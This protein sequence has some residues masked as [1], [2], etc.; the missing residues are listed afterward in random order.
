M[1]F[2]G[3]LNTFHS[4]LLKN[5]RIDY[6]QNMVLEVPESIRQIGEVCNFGISSR[7]SENTKLPKII[8]EFNCYLGSEG[9]SLIEAFVKS[10][11]TATVEKL[12]IGD[13][14]D[15]T[16]RY[17]MIDYRKIVEI[18]SNAEY[19]NLKTLELGVWELLCNA[20][21]LYGRLGDITVILENMPN[22][23]E[24]NL[25]GSFELNY[26][27][28]LKNLQQLHIILDDDMT[29]IN[30]GYI[31][32][33]TLD[34]LLNSYFPVLNIVSLNLEMEEPQI[35]PF[36]GYRDTHS[37]NMDYSF[38]DLFLSGQ[39]WPNLQNLF[40]LGGYL[41]GEID[42]LKL[43]PFVKRND[44]EIKVNHYSR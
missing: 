32:Q 7:T 42:K 11:Y 27:I 39:T 41:E 12:S 28:K 24:L 6:F 25:Y 26:P 9:Q 34:N 16:R 35:Y 3:W 22:L 37:N 2:R 18:L 15:S 13:S 43:C 8:K 30:G 19:P 14:S 33:E 10:P 29:G 1:T 21:C 38:T 23:E 4:G 20:H 40:L 36:E 17:G 31:T 44:T 5:R